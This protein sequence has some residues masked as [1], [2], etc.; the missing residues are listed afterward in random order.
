MRG[1]WI[2]LTFGC[3]A[4]G[5]SAQP[6]PEEKARFGVVPNFEFYP[7]NTPRAALATAIKLLEA[8]RYDYFL[9]HI[10]DAEVLGAKIADRAGKIEP[11]VEKQ[12]LAK[13]DEQKRSPEPVNAR[14]RVPIEPK[15]FS[16][17]VRAEAIDRS[18]RYV[19]ADLKTHLAEYPEHLPLFRK[20]LAEDKLVGT[21]TAAKFTRADAPTQVLHF[22]NDGK[23]WHLEDRQ[24]D[25]PKPMPGK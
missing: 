17:A 7:Q 16:A 20:F 22:T 8:K 6:V 18:F 11:D 24:T 23:R 21:G 10:V 25:E 1:L 19:V 12:L 3:V 5:A 14:D 13:R 4:A 9:A 15:E 2:L